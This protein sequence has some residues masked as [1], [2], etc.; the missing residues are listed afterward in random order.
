MQ[1]VIITYLFIES[2]ILLSHLSSIQDNEP[3]NPKVFGL[4]MDRDLTKVVCMLIICNKKA[5]VRGVFS[6]PQVKRF[7]RDI[8]EKGTTQKLKISKL[9]DFDKQVVYIGVVDPAESK[10]EA[11]SFIVFLTTFVKNLEKIPKN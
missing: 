8:P 3:Q 9:T 6:H 2:L 7:G 10:S 1:I 11:N 4:A 5:A